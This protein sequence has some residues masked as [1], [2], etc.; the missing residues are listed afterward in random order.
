LVI[1]RIYILVANNVCSIPADAS[2]TTLLSI[3]D[4]LRIVGMETLAG[5][6]FPSCPFDPSPQR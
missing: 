3:D 6:L 4:E 2:T 1:D 5:E